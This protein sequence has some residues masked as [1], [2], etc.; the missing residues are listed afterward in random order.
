MFWGFLA[1]ALLIAAQ[2]EPVI[3]L[4]VL[5]VYLFV[6]VFLHMAVGNR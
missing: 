2:F 6:W 4:P 3:F 1:F 5:A